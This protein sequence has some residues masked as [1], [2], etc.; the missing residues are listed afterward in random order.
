MKREISLSEW[1]VMRVLWA[2]NQLTSRQI[3]ERLIDDMDW[4][5]KTIKTLLNRLVKKGYVTVIV[6]GR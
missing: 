5:D 2:E 3:V 6:E 1:Q 4:N